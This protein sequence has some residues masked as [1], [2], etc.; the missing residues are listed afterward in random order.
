MIRLFNATDRFAT[1]GMMLMAALPLIAIGA[2][3][4]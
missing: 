4:H 2:L 3:A 1:V